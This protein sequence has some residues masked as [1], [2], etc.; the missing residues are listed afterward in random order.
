[1][2]IDAAAAFHFT[3]IQKP[4]SMTDQIG[5]YVGTF[6]LLGLLAYGYTLMPQRLRCAR[7]RLDTSSEQR[8]CG[9]TDLCPNRSWSD[10]SAGAVC[11]RQFWCTGPW[12]ATS[13]TISSAAND[14]KSLRIT[15]I[16][17]GDHTHRLQSALDVGATAQIQGPFGRFLRKP[18][19]APEIWI[20]GGSG[21]TRF[22][23]WAQA[24]PASGP[25]INLFH[26]VP[27]ADLANH[28]PE[29]KA[30]FAA[31]PNAHYHLISRAWRPPRSGRSPV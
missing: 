20:A 29:T 3:F 17:L 13:F 2:E 7:L 23:A 16:A 15:A 4:F 19:A 12:G 8:R 9:G 10:P 1:L 25:D 14:E 22:A 28:H 5:L 21:I 11:L 6:C 24:L 26:C 30:A 27:S 18:T 31:V